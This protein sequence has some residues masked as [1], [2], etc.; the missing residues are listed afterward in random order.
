MCMPHRHGA[1]VLHGLLHGHAWAIEAVSSQR[2]HSSQS[3]WPFDE[4]R[5]MAPLPIV[6]VLVRNRLAVQRIGPTLPSPDSLSSK[7]AASTLKSRE[8]IK[9]GKMYRTDS[10]LAL[11]PTTRNSAQQPHASTS[12]KQIWSVKGQPHPR[13]NAYALTPAIEPARGGMIARQTNCV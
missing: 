9:F 11:L 4:S 12:K 8:D 1:S 13:N 10:K 7:P 5:T 6:R 2:R 3:E